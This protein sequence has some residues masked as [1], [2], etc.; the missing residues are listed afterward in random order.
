M[1]AGNGKQNDRNVHA[2][3]PY[4]FRAGSQ[5]GFY[6]LAGHTRATATHCPTPQGRGGLLGC[7]DNPDQHIAPTTTP[8]LIVRPTADTAP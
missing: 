1:G 2:L 4:S 6:F 3:L 5:S 8:M 7:R